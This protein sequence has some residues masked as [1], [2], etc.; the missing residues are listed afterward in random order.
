M[1]D[2]LYVAI[3]LGFFAGSAALAFVFDRLAQLGEP[4]I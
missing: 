1:S 3:I 4:S 2:L